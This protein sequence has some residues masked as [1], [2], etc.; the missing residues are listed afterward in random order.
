MPR[1]SPFLL[2]ALLTA[3]LL[4]GCSST[5]EDKTAGW[6]TDKIYSEARDELNG[7]A[8]DK[9][10]PLLEKLEGRAAGT[11]LAQQAQLE[12]AY[13]QYKGGE[14][15]QAVAT[16]DRFMKL[17]PASPAYDYALYLKGLVNF[18]DNLGMFSWISRQDLSERDQKA[19]KDSFESFRELVTRFPES[20]YTPD[21]RLRMTYI[22]NSLAQYEVHVARYYFER[23]AYVAAVS[24]AQSAIADY[25]DVPATEEALYILVRSY[26][27]LGMEQLRDDT[28]RVLLASYPQTTLLGKGF[29]AKDNPW[30]KFW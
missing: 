10:V 15:A 28:R 1:F 21:A 12:K 27:A 14:K 24:R 19:A 2:P 13:A 22:V 26:D 7:G 25:K 17:H 30:W 11:P 20:R 5:T 8:Y 9:A 4:G 18:N 23:G 3:A 16:L 29:R 6:S